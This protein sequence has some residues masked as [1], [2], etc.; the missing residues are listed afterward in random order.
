LNDLLD[1]AGKFWTS[2]WMPFELKVRPPTNWNFVSF[3]SNLES[4]SKSAS[5]KSLTASVQS[6]VSVPASLGNESNIPLLSN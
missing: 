3:G 4:L 2:I 1:N 6:S 5:S